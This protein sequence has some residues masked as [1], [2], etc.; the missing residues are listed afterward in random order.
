[1]K[2]LKD[3]KNILSIEDMLNRAQ[4]E[5]ELV[6]GSISQKLSTNRTNG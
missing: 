5:K 6:N 4:G 1:M 3:S 2:V